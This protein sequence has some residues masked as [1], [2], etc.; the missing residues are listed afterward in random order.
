MTLHK[1]HNSELSIEIS[2]LGAELKSLSKIDGDE[3]L[4][5]G[6]APYWQKSSPLLFPIIGNLRD[7][8]YT[9]EGQR[10]AMNIHGF[11]SE[12]EFEL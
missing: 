11:A 12:A 9:W 7:A 1:L 2:S 5:Q 8:A 10:Y 4:W 3:F 6:T